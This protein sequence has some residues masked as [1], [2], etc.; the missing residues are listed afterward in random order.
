MAPTLLIF[1]CRD[2]VR[3]SVLAL[4]S[5]WQ[6]DLVTVPP[7]HRAWSRFP[8]G[9]FFLC[10]CVFVSMCGDENP[11]IFIFFFL[12]TL[13]LLCMEYASESEMHVGRP[14]SIM[15]KRF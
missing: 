8:N 9:G 11:A 7:E 14:K 6:F 3:A 4:C 13:Y 10:V 12:S 2:E 15:K 1:R 5:K